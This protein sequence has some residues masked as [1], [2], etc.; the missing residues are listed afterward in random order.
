MKTLKQLIQEEILALLDDAIDFEID[1]Q[2]DNV[3][4]A[5]REAII[6]FEQAQH[7]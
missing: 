3:A 1:S 5:A 7:Y 4:L 6:S 2:T